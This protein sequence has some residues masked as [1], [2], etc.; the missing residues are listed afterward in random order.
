MRASE[1][2]RHMTDVLVMHGDVEVKINLLQRDANG[3][4][5]QRGVVP[6]SFCKIVNKNQVAFNGEMSEFKIEDVY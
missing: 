1:I 3:S 2:V 4:T 5:R 6:I